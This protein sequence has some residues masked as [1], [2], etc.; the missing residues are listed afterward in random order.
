VAHRLARTVL[1]LALAGLGFSLVDGSAPPALRTTD[2]LA[3]ANPARAGA[4]RV[5]FLGG[6]L[7]DREV[8]A[9][10]AALAAS[11]HPGVMLL[12]SAEARPNVKRFLAD[13]RPSQVIPVGRFDE[14]LQELEE[15]LGTP[16]ASPLDWDGGPPLA[17]W[18]A[19]F[20]TAP[21]VVVCSAEPRRLLLQAVCLAG[22][23]RAPLFMLSGQPRERADL[24]RLLAGWRTRQVY[25][26]GAASR[27]RADLPGMRILRLADEKGVAA[28]YLREQRKQGPIPNLV[29]TNPADLRRGLPA[30]S[31][32]APW[33]SLQRRA[34]L[35]CTNE[36]G[37]NAAH[38]I[39]AA[40]RDPALRRAD[41]LIFV[42][43]LKAIPP[44]R[45]P[46]PIPGKDPHIEM[47]PVTPVGNE[48]FTFAVGR[49]FHWDPAVLALQLARRRLV[50]AKS[51]PRRALI[52]SNPGGSLPLLETFSRHTAKE[53]RNAGYQTTTRFGAEV[54]RDEVRRLLPEQDLFLWEGHH[55]TMAHTYGLPEWPEPLPASLIFLQSCLALCPAEA[56]PLLER[57]VVGV[58]GTSTRTYSATGGAC[59]LAFF[60]ALVYEGQTLGG[61][62]RQ[63]KNFLLTYALLKDKRLGPDVK[64]RGA[65]LRSAWAFSLWGDPTLR[66]HRP[67]AR[68]GAL[69]SVHHEVHGSTLTVALPEKAYDRVVVGPYQAEMLPNARLAGLLQ[70]EDEA[71]RRLVP[72]V[73]AEVALPHGPPGKVPHL[74][75]RLPEDNWVFCWDERRRCGYLLITP[76]ARDRNALRFQI[77]WEHERL[78]PTRSASRPQTMR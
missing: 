69:S 16:L 53:L 10:T 15:C 65:N 31:V 62:L 25:L 40:V 9:F 3:W 71:R 2:P 23:L 24:R 39:Q 46:N 49:L 41:G 29:V 47:E 48:P 27:L 43:G 14:D 35:L 42:A 77:D 70:K 26:A 76:R 74:R 22:A 36:A 60:D 4:D 72:F 21:R 12:D 54:T 1:F 57:G 19:L 64:L 7:G 73:F 50:E 61:G 78:E 67:D 37:D 28:R 34:A 5:V 32:L 55:N 75:S 30:M 8:L 59:A 66:L 68:T 33:V 17:L 63:A 13:F 44:E 18:Q 51:G 20:P 56:Y 11:R 6:N 38:V 52:V 58:V 45:R